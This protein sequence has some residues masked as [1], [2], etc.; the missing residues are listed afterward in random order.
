MTSIRILAVVVGLTVAATG[1][2]GQTSDDL[3]NASVLHRI[4]INLHSSDWAKLK[5]NF[6]TNEYYPADVT[7]NGQTVRNVGIRSRGTGSRSGV[8]PGLRVDIDRYATSQLFLGLKGFVLRNQTQDSS[9]IHETTAMWLYGKM[10]IPAPR[11]SHARLYVNGQYQGTYV[12]VEE[13]D[14]KFLARV[15]GIVD[16][17]VQNDG[18]LYE[19]NWIDEWRFSYFGSGLEPYKLRFS[20]KTHESKPDEDLYRP[21]ETLVRLVNETPS[22]GLAAAIGDRLDLTQFMRYLAVQQF[23]AEN[24][25]FAGNWA[26][27]NFYIYRLENQSKHVM[28]AWDASESFLGPRLDVQLRFG[29]NVLVRKLMEIPQ[30]RDAFLNALNETA[31]VAAEGNALDTEIRRALD[32]ID[33]A[34]RED[35]FKPFSDSDFVNGGNAMKQFAGERIAYVKCEVRRLTGQSSNSC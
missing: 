1:I 12:V 34:V 29:D 13:I 19:Y 3:F 10:G 16:D 22:S 9:F 5:Q 2:Q 24:D 11:T 4:D 33:T 23:T 32:L 35:T 31:D 30:F 27:N 28:I 21:L 26:I 14:K 15:F 17:N 18:Y 8:K 6:Q 25:G 7:W 20:P